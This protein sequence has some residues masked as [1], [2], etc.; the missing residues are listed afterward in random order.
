MEGGITVTG[1]SSGYQT[2]VDAIIRPPR[3]VY[4][5][6]D[7]GP[8]V[9][10]IG[11]ALFERKDYQLK[12]PKGMTLQ[13]SHYQPKE[14]TQAKLPCVMY[15][16]GNCGCRLDAM[17]CLHI[18]LPYNI[19]LV[20]LDFCGSGISEGEYVSLGYYERE[21]V[22]TVVDFLRSSG[23]VSKIGLW[24]RS[25]GAAT[26]LMY[27][28]TDPSIACMVLDSPFSS[29][30]KVAKELVETSQI[31]IPKMMVNLGL[32]MIR[33]TIS[34]QGKFDINKLEPIEAAR[35]CFV[36]VLFAHGE[37]DTF[38]G[39]HHSQEIYDAYAG[40]KNII[41]VEG[42]HNSMRPGFF[43]DSVSIFFHNM[44]LSDEEQQNANVASGKSYHHPMSDYLFSTQMKGAQYEPS[45]EDLEEEMLR[46]ALLLS[47]QDA[48]ENGDCGKTL[49]T[50]D[51][52]KDNE[53]SRERSLSASSQNSEKSSDDDPTPKKRK[54]RKKKRAKS[55]LNSL[56]S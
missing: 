15:L 56:G 32:K 29:L 6:E 47:L 49:S 4:D 43:F 38:I 16:H 13:V 52:E 44:L 53:D 50:S 31:K 46:Q 51:D 7:L 11:D 12:N 34:K 25:M 45:F 17:D 5:I 20:S 36:P 10:S 40:D 27:G 23:T 18:L 24:G 8:K 30:T 48:E 9:F 33:K 22:V 21:D 28:S 14:R 35:T 1:I 39:V 3:T 54:V 42:D 55:L 37:S 26:S 2:L 19:T 41:L